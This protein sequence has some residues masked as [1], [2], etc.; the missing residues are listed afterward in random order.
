D[1]HLHQFADT[2]LVKFCKW[3]VLVDL[4]VIVSVEELTS[5]VTGE[6]ECH[7][8]QVVCT[9]AEEVSFFCDLVSCK[10][11]SRDLDHCTNFVFKVDTSCCD[12]SVS[13]FNNEVLHVFKLFYFSNKRN[14][15]FRFD[16]PVRMSFLYVDSCTDNS[17]C[18]HLC[19]FRISNCKTASTMTHHRV[20]LVQAVDDCFDLLYSLALSFCKFL[21]IFFLCWNELMKRRIQE[22]DCYRVTFQ[23]FVESFEV[24]LLIWKNFFKSCFSF[25]FCF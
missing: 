20:E 5:V 10:S 19:N 21:D 3:I 22:T 9:E 15:D 7:L 1:S 25:F 2:N 11:S 17:F 24:S 4:S 18:L 8:C 13:C 14:H 12:F 6:S 16:V 23:S